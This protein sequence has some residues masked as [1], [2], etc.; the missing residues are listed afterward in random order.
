MKVLQAFAKH[1]VILAGVPPVSLSAGVGFAPPWARRLN[2]ARPSADG[3]VLRKPFMN[4]GRRF[5]GARLDAP[6]LH[7]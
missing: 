5:I 1:H 6:T 2:C 4:C 7:I 3:T